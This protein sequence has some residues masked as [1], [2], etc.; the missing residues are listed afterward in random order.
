ML[1]DYFY[2]N[3]GFSFKKSLPPWKSTV[4]E[5]TIEIWSAGRWSSLLQVLVVFGYIIGSEI[6]GRRGEDIEEDQGGGGERVSEGEYIVGSPSIF[7]L[8]SQTNTRL[9]RNPEEA[10]VVQIIECLQKIYISLT[11]LQMSWCSLAGFFDRVEQF[12]FKVQ[13]PLKNMTLEESRKLTAISI[14]TICLCQGI[15]SFAGVFRALCHKYVGVSFTRV[16]YI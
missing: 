12:A 13:I 14:E 6:Q 10:T 3:R 15:A 1:L 4:R 16:T 8:Q 7:R 5:I 11:R 9:S 2:L